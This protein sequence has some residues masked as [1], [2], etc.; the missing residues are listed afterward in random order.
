L[1]C[2]LVAESF[3][4]LG[5]LPG[6]WD[7]PTSTIVLHRLQPTPLQQ[8]ALQYCEKAVQLVEVRLRNGGR[9]Q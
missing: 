9:M 6:S 7:Q 5:E 4:S 8:L 2:H 3:K 1:P